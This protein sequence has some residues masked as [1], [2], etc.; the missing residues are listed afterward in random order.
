[1]FVS[2]REKKMGDREVR[3][4]CV[5]FPVWGQKVKV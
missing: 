1:M 4:G 5:K 2:G 3:T